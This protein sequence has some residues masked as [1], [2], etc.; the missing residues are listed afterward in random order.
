MAKSL[1]KVKV[2]LGIMIVPLYT[3]SCNQEEPTKSGKLSA[4]HELKTDY[5]KSIAR[6]QFAKTLSIS[7]D[8]SPQ[9]KKLLKKEALRTFDVNTDVLYQ[10]IKNVKLE[11]G[12][13]VRDLLTQNWSK[14][15]YTLA[16][17]EKNDPLLNIFASDL[18][19]FDK[20]LSVKKWD[21]SKYF[22]VSS[23]W[24]GKDVL[25][26][27]GDS[28]AV[29]GSNEIPS[30]PTFVIGENRRVKISSKKLRSLDGQIDYTFEFTNPA[31]NG[32]K[33]KN[34]IKSGY[35]YDQDNNT[36]NQYSCDEC[37]LDRPESQLY[38]D[39][40]NKTCSG[41]IKNIDQRSLIYYGNKGNLD[42]SINECLYRFKL[43]PGGYFHIAEDEDPH[44]KRD[45]QSS[46]INELCL[47]QVINELWT[48]GSFEFCFDVF[49]PLKDKTNLET[50]VIIPV[51]PKDLFV[52]NV[53]SKRKHPTWF[54][55]TKY[56]YWVDKNNFGSKWVYPH[57]ITGEYCRI[58]GS[59]DL[60][61]QGLEKLIVVSELDKGE[62]RTTDI[63]GDVEFLY[64][65]E[66]TFGINF[67]ISDLGIDANSKSSGS[68]KVVSGYKV[69]RT[70][71]DTDDRLGSLLLE[72]SDPVIKTLILDSDVE[73]PDRSIRKKDIA[74]FNNVSNGIISA[75]F[76]PY[77]N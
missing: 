8:K 45:S 28:V 54:S 75:T 49:S 44:I 55:H 7:L 47:Q 3:T 74:L 67:K 65:F 6:N 18:G 9:L 5:N 31:F 15:E 69:T 52:M 59:W 48:E 30:I 39:V 36:D 29:I 26:I 43:N 27:S 17:I 41:E 19:L 32:L 25:Y 37:Y 60:S 50:K 23:K 38:I 4:T 11:N 40:Y 62:T 12:I 13:S 16:D 63:T 56:T 35:L 10:S 70:Y 51:Y 22:G 42:R 77:K 71:T 24:Y 68:Y 61:K 34:K 76:L 46:Y 33:G 57:L 58:S 73:Y 64:G 20:N 21:I 72:F 1:L 2:L 66:S 53:Q 14:G